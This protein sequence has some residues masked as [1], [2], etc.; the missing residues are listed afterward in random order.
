MELIREIRTIYDNYPELE[1]RDPGG[2]DPPSDAR[3]ASGESG[4]RRRDGAAE[5]V[6]A[7]DRAS[8]DRQ[9]PR[10][11]PGRLG[12]DGADG[13]A[14]VR[15]EPPRHQ[16][17]RVRSAERCRRQRP[18]FHAKPRRR[19]EDAKDESSSARSAIQI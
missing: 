11:V 17:A 7:A 10:R 12:E 9:G 15:I 3:D 16:A 13:A 14:E 1:T 6:Q 8:A 2:L 4:R 19:E 18:K 5:R